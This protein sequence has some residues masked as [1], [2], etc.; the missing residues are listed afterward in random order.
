VGSALVSLIAEAGASPR[1][2]EQVETYVG[3]LKAAG[4]PHGT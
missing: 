2:V 1:L 3:S 4:L